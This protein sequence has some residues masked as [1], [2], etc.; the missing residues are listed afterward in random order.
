MYSTDEH[1][2][3]FRAHSGTM[4]ELSQKMEKQLQAFHHGFIFTNMK[5]LII[6]MGCRIR[7]LFCGN[8]CLVI[9]CQV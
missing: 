7:Q 9:T 1:N 2:V 6:T 8:N 4:R 3:S 5:S